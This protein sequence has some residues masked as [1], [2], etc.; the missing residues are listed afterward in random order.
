MRNFYPSPQQLNNILG[1]VS[2]IPNSS[3]LIPHSVQDMIA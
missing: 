3:F 1:R 2:G